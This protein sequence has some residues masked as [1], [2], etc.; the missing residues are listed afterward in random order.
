M[1]VDSH[2]CD[3]RDLAWRGLNATK[4]MTSVPGPVIPM[5]DH[6]LIRHRRAARVRR[7][8]VPDGSTVDVNQLLG[9]LK[10][11]R[12]RIGVEVSP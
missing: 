2:R 3:Q 7:L 11:A 10:A 8:R 12:L 5:C 9:K 6:R 4:L 1:L